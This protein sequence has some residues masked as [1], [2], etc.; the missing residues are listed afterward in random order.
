M[1]HAYKAP[2]DWQE[3]NE[4]TRTN[5]AAVVQGILPPDLLAQINS[6]IDTYLSGESETGL[7]ATGRASYDDFLGHKTIRLHGLVSKFPAAGE[8]IS[9]PAV[10]AWATALLSPQAKQI[11]LNA[12]ELIQIEPGEG[13]QQAHRDSDSWPLP[14][15]QDPVIV[16]PF[17]PW[18]I[19]PWKTAQPGS[20][21]TPG[22]GQKTAVRKKVIMN[23]ASCRQG[24]HCFSAVI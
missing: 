18:M 22:S 9:L 2:H 15:M 7:P 19:S 11:L 10:G 1:L 14:L 6:E 3:I 13:K 4:Q 23:V 17:L 8:I 5:G 16:N 12:G 20:H 24:M 21:P